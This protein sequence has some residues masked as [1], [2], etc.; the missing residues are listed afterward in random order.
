MAKSITKKQST[1]F[2]NELVQ[3]FLSNN[4]IQKKEYSKT[5][6][7]SHGFVFEFNTNKY[8]KVEATIFDDNK[9]IYS[10]YM[11]FC[12]NEKLFDARID[13][14]WQFGIYYGLGTTSCKWNTHY[15]NSSEAV[16][17]VIQKIEFLKDK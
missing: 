6:L 13:T 8:G 3:T 7:T 12:D 5:E 2:F 14:N 10:C 17:Q 15:E 4:W 16:R 9:Y 1:A 11:R